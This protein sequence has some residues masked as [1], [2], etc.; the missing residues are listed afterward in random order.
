MLVNFNRYT[1]S[2]GEI[3]QVDSSKM[4]YLAGPVDR[5]VLEFRCMPAMF[6]LLP[7][8]SSLQATGEVEV[9][10]TWLRN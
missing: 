9:R 10:T 2:A 6:T 8:F 7:H 4:S 1:Q 5:G 3:L